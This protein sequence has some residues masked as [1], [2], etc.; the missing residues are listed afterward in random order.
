[1]IDV[2]RAVA[3]DNRLLI[4]EWLKD[5]K[6]HFHPQT[7]GDLVHDGVCGLLI[8]QKLGIRQPTVSAHMKVLTAAGLVTAK[9]FKQWTFYRRDEKC[10]SELKKRFTKSI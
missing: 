10:I 4:L 5:P 7:D 2:L 8:A 9:R 1:M 3:N 6:A